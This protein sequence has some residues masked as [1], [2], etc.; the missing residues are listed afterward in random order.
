MLGISVLRFWYVV[1][2][3]TLACF[4]GFFI[5][6]LVVVAVD[7]VLSLC[8]SYWYF[9]SELSTEVCCCGKV[10]DCIVSAPPAFEKTLVIWE[11]ARPLPYSLIL[12]RFD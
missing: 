7:C 9:S 6:L 10:Y 8:N 12:Y 5:T 2:D 1:L 3:F 11:L 4:L